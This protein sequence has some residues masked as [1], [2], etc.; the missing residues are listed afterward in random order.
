MQREVS[1]SELRNHPSRV[2][3]ALRGGERVVLTSKG[4]PVA[5]IVPRAHLRSP[6]RPSSELRRIIAEAPA[7]PELMRDIGWPDRPRS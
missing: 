7:D 2:I 1:V 5:D 4:M 3:D 6:F